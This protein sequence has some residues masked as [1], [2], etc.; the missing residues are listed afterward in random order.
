VLAA[1]REPEDRRQRVVDLLAARPHDR[2]PSIPLGGLRG[3]VREPVQ[4]GGERPPAPLA[5]ELQRALGVSA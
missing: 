4:T 3:V 2:G 1:R 5:G